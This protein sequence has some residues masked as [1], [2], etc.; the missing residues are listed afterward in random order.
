MFLL[1]E[2]HL[3]LKFHCRITCRPVRLSSIGRWATVQHFQ[4]WPHMFTCLSSMPLSIS[5]LT[6]VAAAC[7]PQS[8][9]LI[10]LTC[11]L[12]YCSRLTT[13]TTKD[14]VS[15]LFSTRHNHTFGIIWQIILFPKPEGRTAK[16]SSHGQTKPRIHLTCSA[17]RDCTEKSFTAWAK[18]QEKSF[19]LTVLLP[20]LSSANRNRV[21]HRYCFQANLKKVQI[22]TF[23]HLIWQ[24]N[25]SCPLPGFMVGV[26]RL[27]WCNHSIFMLQ[28]GWRY[29]RTTT[30]LM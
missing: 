14:F 19:L 1:C 16:T 20:F 26:W 7:K 10:L 28:W 24:R 25:V 13:Q 12:V 5:S 17:I 30:W 18:D 9:F 4:R 21:F 3:Q 8:S 6:A 15:L 23:W 11:F 29:V 27:D 2:L 22:L